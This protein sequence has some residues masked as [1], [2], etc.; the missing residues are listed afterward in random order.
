MEQMIE[1]SREMA[2][3]TARV[4]ESRYALSEHAM[5]NVMTGQFNVADIE[6]VLVSGCVIEEHRHERRGVSYLV[7]AAAHDSPLHALCAPASDG[8]LLVVFAYIPAPPL[9]LD[10]R[11]R[12]PEGG[13]R[14]N[15]PLQTCFFCGG[16][17]KFVTVG[18][19]DYRLEGRLYVI[20]K[21]PAGLCQQCGEKY[22][23]ADVGRQ[24][25][26]LIA[27]GKFTRRE[28]V[29]VIDYEPAAAP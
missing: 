27:E 28:D 26:A 2:W 8:S 14:M 15:A 3:F 25:N 24:M 13:H 9:W 17:I 4:R 29:D 11:H 10:T 5:R 23:A 16:E 22:L 7:C 6:R 19:F 18:N 21:V 1:R 20:K 12:N